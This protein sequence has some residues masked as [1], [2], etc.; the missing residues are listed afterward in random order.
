VATL[1]D[2]R[3]LAEA[4]AI[5]R[6]DG[7]RE[8]RSLV[9]IRELLRTAADPFTREVPHHVTAAAVIARPDASAF[10][11]VHHRRL[12]RWLQPGGH[13]EPQDASVL[14]AARREAREE[15]GVLA[16]DLPFD[17]I[18]DVDVHEIPAAGDRPAH[19]HYD[20]RYLFTTIESE[21]SAALDEVR[22]ARWFPAEMLKDLE[23]DESLLRA[24]AKARRRLGNGGFS[25]SGA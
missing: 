3:Q 23:T 7:P 14:E 20:V 10:L 16:L 9:G 19:V 1:T 15:T 24:I 12:A 4:L 11:L 18:L 6:A 8:E 25:S 21:V 13:V 17:L 2:I 22:E 5:Y